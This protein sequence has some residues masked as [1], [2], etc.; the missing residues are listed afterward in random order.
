MIKPLTSFPGVSFSS[1]RQRKARGPWKLSSL[2]CDPRKL[3]FQGRDPRETWSRG[4][5]IIRK[6]SVY[7]LGVL[8]Y[9]VRSKISKNMPESI[10]YCVGLDFLAFC[11]STLRINNFFYSSA[12]LVFF[13]TT[14]FI[15][16]NLT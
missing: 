7:A 12:T 1:L 11:P 3:S 2:Q 10:I 6:N 8:I 16:S 14:K 13:D 5:Q 9:A 4:Y 15:I